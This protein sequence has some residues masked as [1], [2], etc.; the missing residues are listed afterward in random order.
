[1]VLQDPVYDLIQINEW[2]SKVL[3][4]SKSILTPRKG[5]LFSVRGLVPCCLT[6]I[7]DIRRIS[8]NK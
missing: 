6:K 4:H 8:R 3:L 2:Q 1:M 5:T 7:S